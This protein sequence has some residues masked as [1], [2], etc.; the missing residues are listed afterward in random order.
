M[1]KREREEEVR[2]RVSARERRGGRER[3]VEVFVVLAA[4]AGIWPLLIARSF[5]LAV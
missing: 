4:A 3:E 5:S 1:G 2:G